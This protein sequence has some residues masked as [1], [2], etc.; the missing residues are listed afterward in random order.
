MLL[1]P[2]NKHNC[3]AMLNTLY[4]PTFSS[5]THESSMALQKEREPLFKLI[6]RVE[7]N[8]K[9]ELN[10]IIC[11]GRNPGDTT[12]WPAVHICLEDYLQLANSIIS[13]CMDIVDVD[14]ISKRVRKAD[15]GIS[16][17]TLER[18]P[19]S[20]GSDAT[21]TSEQSVQG[22]RKRSVS[23]K[24][25]GS[26]LERLARD[27]M[28]MGRRKSA[29]DEEQST[30]V[31]STPVAPSGFDTD[32]PKALRKIRSFGNIGNMRLSMSGSSSY[33]QLPSHWETP[34][35]DVAEMKEE[36]QRFEARMASK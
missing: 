19:S 29:E 16:F 10:S 9:T 8:G 11:H 28:S 22:R 3:L 4:P 25:Q 30:S 15:S 35:F 27:L 14:D 32:K 18:R 33:A 21:N 17:S 12:G 34:A 23:V 24:K 13:E 20:S 1:A 2:L 5:D 36:R 26:T 6:N 7:Q 31:E